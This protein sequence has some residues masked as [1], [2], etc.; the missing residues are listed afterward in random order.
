MTVHTGCKKADRCHVDSLLNIS[1]ESF[2]KVSL[3]GVPIQSAWEQ[4]SKG[5]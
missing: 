2:A 3:Y 4:V 1:E 5:N